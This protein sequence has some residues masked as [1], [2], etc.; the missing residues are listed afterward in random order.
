MRVGGEGKDIREE[1][2]EGGKEIRREGKDK[3]DDEDDNEEPAQIQ[4]KDKNKMRALAGDKQSMMA[5]NARRRKQI[6]RSTGVRAKNRTWDAV[7]VVVVVVAAVFVV[8]VVAVAVVVVVVVVDVLV[9]VIVFEC[10]N[11]YDVPPW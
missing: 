3:N 6:R 1:G 8:V 7:V 11:S 10:K 9:V 4:S 5:R 2:K